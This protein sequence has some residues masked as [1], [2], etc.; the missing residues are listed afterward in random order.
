M[1]YITQSHPDKDSVIIKV[2]G[3]IDRESL[4]ILEE[5]YRKNFESGKRITIDLGKISSVGRTGRDFLRK[6]QDK[7][8]LTQLPT[9]IQMAIGNGKLWDDP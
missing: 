2:E 7:T 6:I 1:V 9:Y 8:Q 3:T 4:P 5:I